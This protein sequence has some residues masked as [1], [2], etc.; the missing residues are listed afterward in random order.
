VKAQIV[1]ET[2]DTSMW[3]GF[4]RKDVQVQTYRVGECERI[5]TAGLGTPYRLE[6]VAVR[7]G[8]VEL[9]V[10]PLLLH[11]SPGGERQVGALE[12]AVGETATLQTLSFDAW[13]HWVVTLE[14][15]A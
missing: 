6:V 8:S 1:V 7:P 4:E 11:H 2:Y 13:G 3:S 9:N 15:I 14:G 10:S 5:D 12:I